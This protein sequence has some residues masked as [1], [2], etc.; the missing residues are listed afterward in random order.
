M[1]CTGAVPKQIH[2]DSKYCVTIR[3]T[4]SALRLSEQIQS[5]NRVVIIGNGGIALELV[6]ALDDIEIVWCSRDR[7]G[8]KFLDE[9]ALKFLLSSKDP[10]INNGSADQ[11]SQMFICTEF[12]KTDRNS[13]FYLAIYI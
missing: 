6:H 12:H 9:G 3:D 11:K 7:F 1:L 4:E 2:H 5:A 13:P 10:K 8:R